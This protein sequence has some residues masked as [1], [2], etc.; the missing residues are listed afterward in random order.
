MRKINILGSEYTII[1]RDF[2]DEPVFEKRQI[3]GWCDS[4][5]K[6]I[7]FCNMRTHPNLVDEN[8]AFC[9][10]CERYTIRHEVAHAFLHE[11]GLA[12]SSIQYQQ[13]WA[14][15]EEMVDWIAIQYPKMLKVYLELG[16]VADN[17]IRHHIYDG[18][19]YDEPR[20]KGAKK[21]AG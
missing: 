18:C 10:S 21:N 9:S 20:D 15:N 3:D 16:V 1:R 4:H 14:T 19:E 2:K 11:S 12:E 17:D 6:E 5:N 8:D 13:G 7:V